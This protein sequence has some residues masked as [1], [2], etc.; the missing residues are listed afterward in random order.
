MQTRELIALG[1]TAA[2]VLLLLGSAGR[3]NILVGGVAVFGALAVPPIVAWKRAHHQRLAI[4]VLTG[5]AAVAVVLPGALGWIAEIPWT[6]P[7]V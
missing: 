4:T 3:L 7:L 6:V 2:I 5:L 1:V